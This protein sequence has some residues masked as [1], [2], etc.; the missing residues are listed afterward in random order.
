[1]NNVEI[2]YGTLTEVATPVVVEKSWDAIIVEAEEVA[3]ELTEAHFGDVDTGYGYYDPD[4]P[5]ITPRGHEIYCGVTGKNTGQAQQLMRCTV[6]LYDPDGIERATTY[7]EYVVYP[8]VT[9]RSGNTARVELD[10]A[11]IWVVYGKLE[12]EPA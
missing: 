7:N 10:K 9:I 4:F 12:A 3:G 8:G 6:I 1:M 2:R 5:V 11:G